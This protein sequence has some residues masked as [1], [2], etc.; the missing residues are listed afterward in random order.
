MDRQYRTLSIGWQGSHLGR[1]LTLVPPLEPTTENTYPMHAAE[2]PRGPVV[3]ATP[4]LHSYDAG[5]SNRPLLSL[6][7]RFDALHHDCVVALRPKDRHSQ[8]S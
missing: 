7:A 5:S 3:A 8:L 1:P 4:Q 6:T 2:P